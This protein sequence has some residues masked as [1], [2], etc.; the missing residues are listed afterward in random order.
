MPI[1]PGGQKCPLAHDWARDSQARP[2]EIGRTDLLAAAFMCPACSHGPHTQASSICSAEACAHFRF[3]LP[4][5]HSPA[6]RKRLELMLTASAD[7]LM[8][9]SEIGELA[10]VSASEVGF[11][12]TVARLSK[13]SGCAIAREAWEGMKHLIHRRRRG[14]AQGFSSLALTYDPSPERAFARIEVPF[15]TVHQR[16]RRRCTSPGPDGRHGR[17]AS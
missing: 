1:N 3:R 8:R 4:G 6:A 10:C 16:H 5:A 14:A 9:E 2:R 17:T 13:E 7:D 15:E 11:G 12:S